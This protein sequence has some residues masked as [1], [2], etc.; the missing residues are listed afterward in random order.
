MRDIVAY[1]E[2][3]REIAVHRQAL[4]AGG[5]SKTEAVCKYPF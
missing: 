2:S 4:K 3:K 1:Q 5:Q